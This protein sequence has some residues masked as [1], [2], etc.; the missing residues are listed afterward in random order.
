MSGLWIAYASCRS[1]RP[2]LAHQGLRPGGYR[3]RDGLLHGCLFKQGDRPL[4]QGVTLPDAFH[5]QLARCFF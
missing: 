5:H 1:A 2:Y 4:Q 3:L